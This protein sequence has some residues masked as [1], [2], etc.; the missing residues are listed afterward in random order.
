MSGFNKAFYSLVV[1]GLK[2]R[3]ARTRRI[4]NDAYSLGEIYSRA[5]EKIIQARRREVSRLLEKFLFWIA[6]RLPRALAY[7]ATIRLAA[8]ATTGAKF[9]KT[10][11]PELHMMDV[12]KRWDLCSDCGG[13]RKHAV[14]V[15]DAP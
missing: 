4:V 10:V 3:I 7:F 13:M 11:V 8:H 9:G 12:L 5:C 15:K 2:R 1:L 14:C 6:W